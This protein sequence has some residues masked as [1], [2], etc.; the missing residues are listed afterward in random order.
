MLEEFLKKETM[1]IEVNTQPVVINEVKPVMKSAI[2][3]T[4]DRLD[5]SN[6]PVEPMQVI[7]AKEPVTS[8]TNK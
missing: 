4:D 5:E 3:Q 6:L 8:L 1:E 7:I 2:V